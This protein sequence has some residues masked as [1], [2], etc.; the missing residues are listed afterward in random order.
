MLSC[1]RTTNP[2]A[3]GSTPS[4]RTIEGRG[5]EHRPPAHVPGCEGGDGGRRGCAAHGPGP[6]GS[7]PR[8]GARR[9][10]GRRRGG[11]GRSRHRPGTE[12][13]GRRPRSHRPRRG[14]GDPSGRGGDGKLPAHGRR[15]LHDDRAVHDVLRRGASRAHRASRV[16]RRRSEDRRRAHA[17]PAAGGCAAESSGGSG[18][19]RARRGMWRALDR[20]LSQEKILKL[21][22]RGGRARLKASDSKSDR[23]ASPSGVQILSP[24]PIFTRAEWFRHAWRGGRVAEGAALEM[25]CRGNSTV[26]SNPTPSANNLVACSS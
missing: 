13:D 1:L 12:P 26:G 8:G 10:G 17:V 15:A 4:C 20:V 23:G 18:G 11:A 9:G 7:P 6:R 2:K 19:G 21:L 22:R 14:G 24:P 5:A 16:R 3:R 25:P